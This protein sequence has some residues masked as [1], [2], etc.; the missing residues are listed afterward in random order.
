MIK[1]L[2]GWRCRVHYGGKTGSGLVRE[3]P[4]SCQTSLLLP[5]CGEICYSVTQS[6]SQPSNELMRQ[7]D[8]QYQVCVY[9]TDSTL[10]WSL[11]MEVN[12]SNQTWK[13]L[14]LILRRLNVPNTTMWKVQGACYCVSWWYLFLGQT[15]THTTLTLIHSCLQYTDDRS[16]KSDTEAKKFQY[17]YL[18]VLCCRNCGKFWGA[19]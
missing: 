13:L 7:S 19:S 2:A 14:I 8:K 17:P 5:I 4:F 11:S 6:Y 1:T 3:A 16:K 12:K 10:W 18:Q 15:N 9:R